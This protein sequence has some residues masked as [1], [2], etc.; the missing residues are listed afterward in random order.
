MA[1]EIASP[2]AE[3]K[4]ETRK[5]YLFDRKSFVTLLRD[6]S[7]K[8]KRKSIAKY[9]ITDS[10]EEIKLEMGS[11]P[12]LKGLSRGNGAFNDAASISVTSPSAIDDAKTDL[13]FGLKRM[14]PSKETKDFLPVTK[15]QAALV[16]GAEPDVGAKP[17][18]AHHRP[19][20][21]EGQGESIAVNEIAHILYHDDSKLD[22]DMSFTEITPA[23]IREAGLREL[24]PGVRNLTLH[25]C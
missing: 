7:F 14:S 18:T 24:Q 17:S 13:R 23:L 15:E 9:S 3:E 8:P 12:G 19:I 21:D 2:I 11:S 25:T 5:S 20:D 10:D 6:I 16:S 22:E 4:R 1:D